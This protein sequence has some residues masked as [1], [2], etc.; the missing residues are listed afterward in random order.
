M[1]LTKYPEGSLRELWHISLPL[2]LSS[3]SV[4]AMIFVDRLL[5][6][7]Y[8]TQALTAGTNATTLGWAFIMGWMSFASIAEVFVAQYNGAGD[9]QRIGEPVWQMIWF[10]LLSFIC[11]VPLSLYGGHWFFGSGPDTE[12]TRQYFKWMMFFGPIFPIYAALCAFFIGQGKPFLI[13]LLAIVSNIVNAGL[14]VILIFGVEGWLPS[15]GVVGAAIATSASSILQVAVLGYIFLRK[16]NREECGTRWYQLNFNSLWQCIRIGFPNSV[17][18]VLEIY[19]WSM[20]YQLMTVAGETHITIVSI[21]QSLFILFF[22]LAE[23]V[24]KAVTAIV[25]NLIGAQKLYHVNSVIMSGMKLHAAFFVLI[26]AGT[27]LGF[28]LIVTFFLPNADAA[29]L[30]H[31]K[32]PLFFCLMCYTVT[33]LLEGIRM[34]F[35]GAL[36]AAG[37]TLFIMIAGVF[38]VWALLVSPVY[39]FIIQEKGSVETAVMIC[40][41]YCLAVTVIYYARFIQGKWRET[42]LVTSE[43]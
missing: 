12:L 29:S 16:K 31:L 6:A 24:S 9:K 27:F 7:N 30:A 26:L 11:F 18:V 5:L 23:G 14:D 33:I 10:S 22:F 42:A 28:D 13:T 3:F 36:T 39:Y 1:S 21:G 41:F 35:S 17:F 15:L 34:L 8:S 38:S 43:V 19:A 40:V 4:M 32:G 2:M 37:D 20:F 25:G